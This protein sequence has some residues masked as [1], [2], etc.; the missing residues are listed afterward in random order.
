MFQKK[1]TKKLLEEHYTPRDVY[2]IFKVPRN[3]NQTAY[4]MGATLGWLSISLEQNSMS[5]DTSENFA[6]K[7]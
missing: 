4:R 6:T 2:K 5:E 3:K 1:K 7:F